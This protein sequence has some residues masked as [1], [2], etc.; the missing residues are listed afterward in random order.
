MNE[1][2]VLDVVLE[3]LRFWKKKSESGGQPIQAGLPISEPENRKPQKRFFL[4]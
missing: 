1:P 2:S 3:K 4:S